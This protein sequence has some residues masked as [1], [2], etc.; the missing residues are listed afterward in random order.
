MQNINKDYFNFISNAAGDFP[1]FTRKAK[2][3]LKVTINV[4]AV[5]RKIMQIKNTEFNLIF[6]RKWILI[7]CALW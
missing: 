7:F 3:M 4:W 1:A 2:I 5:D 6:V